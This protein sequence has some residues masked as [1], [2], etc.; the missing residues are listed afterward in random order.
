M[1]P[2]LDIATQRRH[3]PI[4]YL[5]FGDSE[6][7]VSQ[8]TG[9]AFRRPRKRE[10]WSGSTQS[11]AVAHE[12]AGRY[13][14]E[15]YWW[16]PQ[17]GGTPRWRVD[18]PVKALPVVV[19]P[20]DVAPMSQWW[21]LWD[22]GAAVRRC[23]SVTDMISARPCLCG[24]LRGKSDK[25]CK[26]KTRAV[27]IL[28]EINTLGVWLVTS[29]GYYTATELPTGYELF[30]SRGGYQLARLELQRRKSGK[31]GEG[32]VRRWVTPALDM[33]TRAELAASA[34]MLT[35]GMV[36]ALAAPQ[37]PAIEAAPHP[38]PDEDPTTPVVDVTDVEATAADDGPAPT[39]PLD[40]IASAAD[41]PALH[42]VWARLKDAGLLTKEIADAIKARAAVLPPTAPAQE[43]VGAA[44]EPVAP[45][46]QDEDAANVWMA[47]V[48]LA[49]RLGMD[50]PALEADFADR[51]G[52]PA[53]A[54]SLQDLH[55]YHH[56]LKTRS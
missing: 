56:H 27:F 39:D 23:D 10:T 45:S 21:E 40:D 25:H 15:P 19:P 36:P 26:R 41:R 17:N 46:G 50:T 30:Q 2:M 9:K 18:S 49:G 53:S 42:A 22:R 20:A 43:P 24:D 7:A 35:G 1:P 16:E 12:F 28:P 31:A 54:A 5:H 55:D 14:G 38:E 44:A 4:G 6:E 13:G 47:C 37:V 11:E 32:Q 29:G 8:R 33:P 52:K 3:A 51:M 48:G 34:A